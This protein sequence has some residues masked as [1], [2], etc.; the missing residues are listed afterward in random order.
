MMDSTCTASSQ[1]AAP[2]DASGAF[3]EPISAADPGE[4]AGEKGDGAAA[5]RPV[6]PPDEPAAEN[7]SPAPTQAPPQAPVARSAATSDAEYAAFQDL[8]ISSPPAASAQQ[9]PAPRFESKAVEPAWSGAGSSARASASPDML[10]TVAN[11]TKQGDGISGFFTYDVTTK[12]SLP[13]FQFGQFS[14][15]RRFRD[16]DWLHAQ[17]GA[18]YPGAIV[19]PLPE[20]HATQV[21]TMKVSGIGC[22]AEWLE[23]RRA[24]LQ[25]FLQRVAAHPQLHASLDLQMFLEASEETLEAHK[26]SSKQGKPSTTYALLTDVKAGILSSYARSFSLLS[27]APSNYVAVADVPCQQM[28]NY[29]ATLEAQVTAVHKHSKRYIE[30]HRAL[31]ASLGGFGTALSQLGV[32][33]QEVNGGLARALSQMGLCVDQLA[34]AYDD[35]AAAEAAAFEEPI[36]DYVRLLGQARQAIGARESALKTLNAAGA[37]LEKKKD[38]LERYRHAT[39]KEEKQQSMARD[40]ADA[41]A[42]SACAKQEYDAVS[43]RVDGE[44]AR[45]QREKLADFKVMLSSFI[46]LQVEHSSRVQ[47]MWR[48]LLPHL[49]GVD[50]PA[51]QQQQQQQQQQ[52]Q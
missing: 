48:E 50:A 9:P 41:E 15:T 33:E 24:Q 30:R 51:E 44:M 42:M 2:D 43:A 4:L 31:G 17:L 18:K 20:K 13:Q 28:G 36:K 16:F 7:L 32:C 8:D 40:V 21:Q 26:E 39:H 49:E 35:H 14:V 12:T 27:D 10:V 29:A 46:Q 47:A 6:S 3:L 25:R 52:E 34:R 22:S 1:V 45:F 38:V 37:A 5:A 19:P 11:P 23:E